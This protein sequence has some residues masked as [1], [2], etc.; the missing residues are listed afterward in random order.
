MA[1]HDI[2]V[3]ISADGGQAVRE[4][5]KVKN[6]LQ[7]VSKV[8]ASNSSMND[9]AAGAKNADKEVQK[10]NKDVGSIPG[11]LAK[12]GAAVSAAFTVSA[13]IGVGKAALQAAA[14]IF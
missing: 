2:K 1:N 8:K 12:V 3:T 9:L 5:D 6:A 4:T 14:N 7:S 11:T 10:L 13:I